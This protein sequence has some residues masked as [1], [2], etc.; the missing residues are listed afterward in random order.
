MLETKE[1][2]DPDLMKQAAIVLLRHH[3]ALRIRFKRDSTGWYQF[4][5]EARAIDEDQCFTSIDL[6]D[7]PT[8]AQEA[9]LDQAAV[10]A[11]TSQNLFEGP[12]FQ[13]I[14]FDLGSGLSDRVLFIIH[15]LIFDAISW[16]IMLEDFQSGYLQLQSTAKVVL[17]AQT[18]SLRDWSQRQVQLAQDGSLLGNIDYWLARP[19]RWGVTFPVDMPEGQNTMA[20]V[21]EVRAVLSQSQTQALLETSRQQGRAYNVHSIL[22]ATL[23]QVLCQWSG[24]Q[25]LP[26]LIAFHGRVL[27]SPTMD[28]SRTMGGFAFLMPVCLELRECGAATELWKDIQSQLDSVPAQG[29]GYGAVRYLQGSQEVAKPLTALPKPQISF[30]YRGRLMSQMLAASSLL[31]PAAAAAGP[32]HGQAG[33]RDMLFQLDAEIEQGTLWIAWRYSEQLHRRATIEQMAQ[34]HLDL[35]LMALCDRA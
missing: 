31:K 26:I 1:A 15:H 13:I 6:S 25:Y 10:V 4:I 8:E 20:S 28:L 35:L 34:S 33:G 21:R 3:D 27:F 7:A 16:K 11:H 19:E 2:L 9:A 18:T 12:L 5:T 30:N 32:R 29:L 23:T 22:L 14:H 17:P 24:H